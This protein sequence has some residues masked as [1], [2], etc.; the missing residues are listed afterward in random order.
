MKLSLAL[1]LVLGCSGKAKKADDTAPGTSSSSSSNAAANPGG[2]GGP[3]G[4]PAGGGPTATPAAGGKAQYSCFS[5]TSKN[6]TTRRHAC[7]RTDECGD[8]LEQ[9]KSVP[10]LTNFTGC[11]NT[12]TVFC[13]HQVGTKEDP[14]GQD[15]CQ[16]TLDECKTGRADVLKAKMSVDTDCAQK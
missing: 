16:P 9:A 12:A 3:T 4:S 14:D 15:I 8:Y 10:G 5:Y 2:G 13:F 6:S 7:S 11:A 1:V